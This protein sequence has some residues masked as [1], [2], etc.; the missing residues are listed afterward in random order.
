[1]PRLM[2]GVSGV[3]GVYGD[4]LT[5]EVAE[6]F[7]CAYGRVH[8]GAVVVGRDSRI[9]GGAISG[10][11]KRG[12]RKAGCDVIDLGLATTPTTE[13]ALTA[14]RAV[15][16]VIV[17]ASHNPR[18]WNGLKFLGPEGIFLTASEGQE[19]VDMFETIGDITSIPETGT[20]TAWDGADNLHIDATLGL[21][22]ID[23][24]LIRSKQYTVALDAVNG[25]G[26]AIC[27]DLLERLGCTVHGINLEPTGEFA[28]GAEPIPENVADLCALVY[29][30]CD[31]S[32]HRP[33]RASHRK[34]GAS[35]RGVYAGARSGLPYGQDRR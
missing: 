2:I 35:G 23:T 20:L 1:M 32:R 18:E 25:V 17:T 9:S 15:G 30:F 19:V 29:R 4:G 13:M 26:G 5:E 31:R 16:G 27:V 11:V 12:L 21:D 34:R 7:A 10:A 14:K 6:R 22:L 33:P 28:H 3:R 8:N 24:D